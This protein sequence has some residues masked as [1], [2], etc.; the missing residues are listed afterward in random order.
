MMV[1]SSACKEGT[2][3]TMDNG[4]YVRY[5]PSKLKLWSTS[6]ISSPSQALCVANSSFVS[7]LSSPTSNRNRSKFGSKIAASTLTAT[8]NGHRR[9]HSNTSSLE[10][11]E[12][13]S[14]RNVAP[15]NGGAKYLNDTLGRFSS[16]R[17]QPTL[18]WPLYLMFNVAGRPYDGF[19]YHYNPYDPS[20]T[21]ANG[22]KSMYPMLV[23]TLRLQAVPSLGQGRKGQGAKGEGLCRFNIE[24]LNTRGPYCTA[25]ISPLEMTKAEMEQVEQDPEFVTLSRQFRQL[26]EL[27]VAG[28]DGGLKRKEALLGL[29]IKEMTGSGIFAANGASETTATNSTN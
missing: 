10:C 12:E 8:T 11:D 4:K 25:K 16:V 18:G 15:L 6:T 19:A 1:V 2:K 5:T 9:H 29:Q 27:R 28:S 20:I 22:C 3:I 21:T 13:L 26:L 23:S 14:R 17:I 7:S 24:E